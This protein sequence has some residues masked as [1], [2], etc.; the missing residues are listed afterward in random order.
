[1]TATPAPDS[2]RPCRGFPG[3]FVSAADGQAYSLVRGELR[4]LVP[5]LVHGH[6]TVRLRRLGQ[7]GRPVARQLARLVLA[8]FRGDRSDCRPRFANND[9]A[10]TR[11][12][13]LRWKSTHTRRSPH[14]RLTPPE[15][16]RVRRLLALGVPAVAIARRLDG[17][18]SDD[19]I[20]KIKLRRTYRNGGKS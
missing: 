4:R 7:P 10:D 16:R 9:P 12:S 11:L 3:Y 14:R 19:A 13:N 5:Q 8:N 15:V 17:K 18:V 20:R 2:L 6:L 1:M